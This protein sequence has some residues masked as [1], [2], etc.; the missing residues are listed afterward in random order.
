MDGLY[1]YFFYLVRVV[2][3]SPG[4]PSRERQGLA[5]VRV[6]TCDFLSHVLLMEGVGMTV[7]MA[8]FTRGNGV[9]LTGEEKV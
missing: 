9:A 6:A 4:S 5:L 2:G 7:A 3:I 8:L 1:I